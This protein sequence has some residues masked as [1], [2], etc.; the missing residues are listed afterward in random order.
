LGIL[1]RDN[2]TIFAGVPTMYWAMLAYPAAEEEFD[3]AK[4]SDNLHTAVSGGSAMPV[5]I[6]RNFEERFTVAI[7]EGYGLSETSPV[8]SFNVRRK[9][10]KP[11][12]IGLPIW[13]VDMALV[14]DNDNLIPGPTEEGHNVMKGYY[15]RPDATASVMAMD[16]FHSGDLARID[17]EGYYFIVDRKKEMIL[18]GGFNVYP[19]E[20]E[21]YLLTHPKVSLVAVKSIPDEKLG[22]EVKAY[23]VLNEGESATAEEIIVFAQEGLAAYKYPRHIEFR[24]ELPMTATGKILKRAL[25]DED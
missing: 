12:S 18:R 11:G 8:A 19:R 4:I 2:V 10:R 23:I 21:E 15:K 5:E 14:D 3:I 6:M 7:L 22:E 13:G 9:P 24:S 16:W 20:I 25:V 1:Q 17:H